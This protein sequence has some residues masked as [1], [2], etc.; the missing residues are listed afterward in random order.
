MAI[1][2]LSGTNAISG[3]LPAANI[4]DTSIS[5]ITALPAG[6]GGK[7]LQVVTATKTDTATTSSS[8]FSD[9]TGLSVSLT[10]SSASNKILVI[11]DIS[12]ASNSGLAGVGFRLVQTIS[13][14]DTYP[15]IGD[16]ASSRTRASFGA[17][18]SSDASFQGKYSSSVLLSPN[19]TSAVTIKYQFRSQNSNAVY[20]NR[21]VSDGNSSDQYR[22]ASSI[23]IM[24]IAG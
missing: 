16:S 20:L 15:Y 19:T 17:Y 21:S 12:G 22:N 4:N 8:S 23:T 6:V 18:V 2:R 1:T 24:E 10:P 7:V 3:T 14:S 9:I 13:G 5:N 11:G